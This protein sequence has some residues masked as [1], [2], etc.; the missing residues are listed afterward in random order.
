MIADYFVL[1]RRRLNLNALYQQ[2]GEYCYTRGFSI[3]AL[4]ALLAAILPNLP[5]FLVTVKA[6]DAGSVPAFFVTLYSYAWFVGF[7]IAFC[8]YIALRRLGLR[9]T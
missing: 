3:V 9:N 6:I 7:A 5:G 8:V 4:I 1:R 2:D